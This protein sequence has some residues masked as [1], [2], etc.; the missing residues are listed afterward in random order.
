MPQFERYYTIEE[1]NELLPEIREILEEVRTVRDQLVVGWKRAE[2]VIRA[3]PTNGGGHEVADYIS[4]LSHLSV[5]LRWFSRR[6]I[7]VKDIDRGLVDFP[8]LRDGQEVLLCWELSEESV[9]FWHDLE[10]GYAGRQPW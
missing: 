3:A 6:G 7:V 10:T 1:A 2:P 4:D 8:A 9:R 5:Q